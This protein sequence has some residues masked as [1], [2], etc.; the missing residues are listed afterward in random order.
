LGDVVS[1]EGDAAGGWVV[2]AAEERYDG[3][4]AAA[5]GADKGTVCSG[6]DIERDILQ[7]FRRG[8]LLVVKFDALKPNRRIVLRWLLVL[9]LFSLA[10]SG[11]DCAEPENI[12]GTSFGFRN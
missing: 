1:V 5:R 9:V 10:D 2:E 6:L 12:V 7:N 4:F 3:G 11:F 8:T